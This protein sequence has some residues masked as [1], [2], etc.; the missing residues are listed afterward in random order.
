MR[1]AIRD[2]ARGYGVFDER[3]ATRAEAEASLWRYAHW[4]GELVIVEVTWD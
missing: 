3:F 4:G 2:K 1:Y